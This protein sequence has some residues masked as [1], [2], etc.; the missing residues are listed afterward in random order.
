M[1]NE[2][3]TALMIV[4]MANQTI[5]S[6]DTHKAVQHFEDI[7]SLP[8]L[9]HVKFMV[10]K[11]IL[12]FVDW[13]VHLKKE[14]AQ[15]SFLTNK[16]RPDISDMSE[17]EKEEQRMLYGF[18]GSVQS[19]I[20][21]SYPDYVEVYAFSILVPR[22]TDLQLADVL[23]F[24]DQYQ[25]VE[26]QYFID[27]MIWENKN[28]LHFSNENTWEAIIASVNP[29]NTEQFIEAFSRTVNGADTPQGSQDAWFTLCNSHATTDDTPEYIYTQHVFQNTHITEE[30]LSLDEAQR[31]L[32]AISS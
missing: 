6:H 27:A 28:N 20:A 22:T 5:H 2:D 4:S 32:I 13:A 19:H 29:E 25:G 24:L 16:M 8:L 30:I 18:S 31:N 3:M 15:K 26:K 11:E 1:K 7:T 14:K 10:G 12:S 21:V 17:I 23:S 9:T